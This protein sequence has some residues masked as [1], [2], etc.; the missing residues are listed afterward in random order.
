M[1]LLAG[2][3]GAWTGY[4]V[5]YTGVAKLGGD[6][7]CTIGKAFRGQC[8]QGTAGHGSATGGSGFTRQELATNRYERQ[9]SL[10]PHFP[11]PVGAA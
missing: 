1:I 4:L 2:L 10:V 11:I 9:L 8:Q 5:L 6:A 3:W 7:T